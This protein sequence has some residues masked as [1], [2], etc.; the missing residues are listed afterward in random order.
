MTNAIDFRDLWRQERQRMRAAKS[1]GCDTG[2]A[3][4]ESSKFSIQHEAAIHANQTFLPR[5]NSR[6]SHETS[7]R[8]ENY[9]SRIQVVGDAH[10]IT[11]SRA[12]I[13][14]VFYVQNFLS[15]HVGQSIMSWLSSLPEY[16]HDGLVRQTER[17]ECLRHNGKWTRLIHAR[18]KVAL[19][20]GTICNFPTILQHLSHT[21]VAVGAF[22]SSHPPN[23]VLINEY[24][25]GE[26]ILPHTDGPAY[27]SRTATISLGGSHVIFKLWPRH[28]NHLGASHNTITQPE[29][30]RV[31]TLE[32]ILHGSGSL[33]LFMNEAYLNHCHEISEDILEEVSSPNG[34]C[35]N[36]PKGGTL[37][38]RGHRISLTFRHK[39]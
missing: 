8:C 33:V 5:S 7:Y 23:H 24:Q 37:V 2:A 30:N 11:C 35:G 29:E 13:D 26:G 39:K 9:Y 22:P 25:P 18:R 36:D 10:R 4:D 19:F 6:I 20:D 16:S 31:P 28:Q 17:E 27:E 12:N 3:D 1:N 14:S 21:L 15:P 32:I 34:V 38:T